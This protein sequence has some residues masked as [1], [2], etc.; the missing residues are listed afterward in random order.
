VHDE[1]IARGPTRVA[2]A[3]EAGGD[4]DER[5]A[6]GA[7][8]GEYEIVRHLGSGAMG[9]V[10]AGRHPVIGKQVA[11]K[12]IKRKLAASA[13][14]AERF[15]REARAV[16]RVDHPNVLDVFAFGRLDDGRPYLVMDLLEGESLGDR[17]RRDGALDPAAAVEILTPVCEALAVAHDEGV[18]H[19]DLKPDNVFL[20]RGGRGQADARE[21]VFVLDFG[22]AKVLGDATADTAPGTLTGEGVWIGTPAYMSPEQWTAEGASARSDIYAAGAML[23]E[24][25]T[26]R[27]PY[28]ARS[29]PAMMEK[30]F[31]AEVPPLTS[32]NGDRLPAAWQKVVRQAM[33]KKPDERPADA[34]TL[35]AAARDALAGSGPATPIAGA[36]S[37]VR[38]LWPAA[39][40]AVLAVAAAG[41]LIDMKRRGDRQPEARPGPAAV[42]PAASGARVPVMSTPAGAQVEVDGV[43]VG[44]TPYEIRAAP[45]ETL[46]VRVS[47]P[48]YG[49]VERTVETGDQVVVQV[50]LP[51][52]TGFE[53][54]WQLAGGELRAFERSGDR[55]AGYRLERADGEREFIRFFDFTA[56]DAGVRFAATE[57][58][59][60]ERAPN[61]P[62][63]RFELRAEYHYVPG[64]DELTLRREEVNYD[65]HDGRCTE[66]A[67]RW[68]DPGAARR[69][70]EEARADAV[71]AASHAGAGNVAV[72]APADRKTAV[73]PVQQ[74]LPADEVAAANAP[75]VQERAPAKEPPEQTKQAP[76][77]EPPEQKQV[78]GKEPLPQQA[79]GDQG[80]P[81]AQNAAD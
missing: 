69:L 71:W 25:L 7:H 59:I 68:S 38:R 57:E 21:R 61:E 72:D 73:P 74:P 40:A 60:D 8:A 4:G 45:G 13:E 29:V 26:G 42:E 48:G 67:R 14:A 78:P 64:G 53:G 15:V 66:L 56:A 19:R 2:G 9:D 22:I 35:L 20:A 50:V 65:F 70:D 47:R 52:V 5:L 18:V 80:L 58:T 63:C 76:S 28:Q 23:Y 31:H 17:L 51:P 32:R 77:K 81:P 12:V 36:G 55:V 16:N 1:D 41:V 24:M 3:P 11:V 10:Y 33:A 34:R 37:S 46:Q 62:T 44:N 43:Y 79:A 54:V 6:P 27:V 49:P 30:H 75:A 39:L